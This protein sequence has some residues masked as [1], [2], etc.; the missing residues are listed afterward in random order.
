MET[1]EIEDEEIEDEE[2]IEARKEEQRREQKARAV[3]M[4][5]REKYALKPTVSAGHGHSHRCLGAAQRATDP[6]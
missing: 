5:W 3:A 2:Q 6:R 1:D 4:G